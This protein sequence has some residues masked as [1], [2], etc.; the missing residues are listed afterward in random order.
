MRRPAT[1]T[2]PG[3]STP[4]DET[5]ALPASRYTDPAVFEHEQRSIFSASW[6]FVGMIEEVARPGDFFTADAGR[7]PVL[8]VRDDS[9][10]RAFANVC[11]HR[12]S[13]L[14][15]EASGSRRSLQCGYHAWTYDLDGS[16][17]AA[18]G[19]KDEA[20]FDAA[21]LHLYP[22]SVDTWGP[23]V[24][25][26]PDRD[27]SP[28]SDTL[29][30]LPQLTRD[31]GAR[32]GEIRRRR[33]QRYEIRANWKVVV[34]NYLECYH[35]RVAHPSF[36]DVVDVGD[37]A[38]EEYGR[39]S[40]QRAPGRGIEA[41][42]PVTAGFYAYLWPNFA[43]NI[44]PGAGH[45]SLNRFEPLD[46]DRTLAIF[47]YCFLDGTPESEID[48]FAAFV[49]QVQRED[50][51]LCESVQRGLRSGVFDQGRLMLSRERAL[52]HFQNLVRAALA[53][54]VE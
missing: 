5:A 13:V 27:A 3:S 41:G 54:P 1:R 43:L 36:C 37:Y 19:S 4:I 31:T 16:L 40:V 23:L 28:L 47:D 12:G 51:A 52:R 46:V 30:E 44:Y 17:R 7:L 6:Q 34:D 24:F 20:G 2:V 11:R 53:L 9:S 14:V 18:P 33:T 45:V 49:D 29:A 8:V 32:L 48:D 22:L 50:T 42:A 15:Q 38:V 39:F 26:N 35:C 10:L 21:A 25:V